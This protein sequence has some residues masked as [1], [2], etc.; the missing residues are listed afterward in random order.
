MSVDS[1][2]LE[3]TT[4]KL[5]LYD[6][7]SDITR[8]LIEKIIRKEPTYFHEL[9][10]IVNDNGGI[11]SDL[12]AQ[13][14]EIKYQMLF[15]NKTEKEA[16]KIALKTAQRIVKEKNLLPDSNIQE[17]EQTLLENVLTYEEKQQLKAI[18]TSY[19]PNKEISKNCRKSNPLFDSKDVTTDSCCLELYTRITSAVNHIKNFLITKSLNLNAI[20]LSDIAPSLPTY[21]IDMNDPKNFFKYLKK[22]LDEHRITET[23]LLKLSYNIQWLARFLDMKQQWLSIFNVKPEPKP[24]PKQ[25]LIIPDDSINEALIEKV[26]TELLKVC[27]KYTKITVTHNNGI[28]ISKQCIDDDGNLMGDDECCP[29]VKQ[30]VTDFLHDTTE[31]F[32]KNH[33][34]DDERQLK[35][36]F[37]QEPIIDENFF[38]LLDKRNY[39]CMD[40]RTTTKFAKLIG[41]SFNQK[42]KY[43]LQ[44]ERTVGGGSHSHRK[45]RISKKSRKSHRRRRH[46]HRRL[47]HNKKHHTKR[48]TKR[49]RKRK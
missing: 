30:F 4:R 40:D 23:D 20:T 13:I 43:G 3:Y 29:T 9:Y 38:E 12:L 48:H 47:S 6:D 22:C 39:P 26:K 18:L 1:F 31:V 10:K 28:I 34:P 21:T 45:R 42:T 25:V 19:F 41:H 36:Y 2:P 17:L 8:S 15:N 44:D 37:E 32:D 49:Y 46:H 16:Q 33:I 14:V 7:Q 24:E 27:S 5:E 35:L 11:Q